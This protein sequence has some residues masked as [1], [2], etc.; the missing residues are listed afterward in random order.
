MNKEEQLLNL[1]GLAQR[2]GK[3]VSGEDLVIK[4]IQSNQAQL[5]FLAQDAGPNLKKTIED[6]SR[7]YQ[8]MVVDQFTTHELSLAI[9]RQRKVLSVVDS[10]FAKKMRS[11]MS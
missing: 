5:V 1:L 9:G 2:A 11:I 8:K 6:K 3:L 10:G 4:S 7:Y